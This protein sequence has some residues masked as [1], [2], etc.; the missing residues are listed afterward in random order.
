MQLRLTVIDPTGSHPAVDCIV[1]VAADTMLGAV[2][3]SLLATVGRSD[4]RLFC[5]GQPLTDQTPLGLPPLVDGAVVSAGRPLGQ[6]AKTLLEL[7]VT[8]GPDSGTVHP[9]GPGEHRIGR[10]LKADVRIEDP[11]VSRLHA[12]LSVRPGGV[13]V[14]DLDSTNGTVVGGLQASRTGVPMEVGDVLQVGV[15]RLQLQA[16]DL[17]RAACHA[18]GEGHLQLN[19]PPRLPP[20]E[21]SPTVTL[22]AEPT[23]REKPRV[24][25]IAL[26]VPLVAGIALVAFTGNP[27]YLAF[28]LL[29]PLMVLGT[30]LTDRFGGRRSARAEQ[31][32]Y[33]EALADAYKVIATA[34]ETEE[35]ARHRAHPGA[36]TLLLAATAPTPR[37]WERRR[38]DLD[39]L[40]LR[41]GLADLPAAVGVQE[42]GERSAERPV[43]RS[44]PVTVPLA[45][46][47][48]VGFAGTRRGALAAARFALAQLVAWHSPR[49]L[50]VVLL[51]TDGGGG[52]WDW[53]RWLPHLRPVDGEDAELLVALDSDRVRARL[54]ELGRLLDARAEETSRSRQGR[55]EGRSVVVVLDG[56]R[57]L[58]RVPGVAR[59]LAEGPELG[60]HVLC[61]DEHAVALPVECGATIEVVGETDTALRVTVR[62]SE[63]LDDVVMDGVS[64][65]WANR[66]ARALAPL[67]DATPDEAVA[68]LPTEVGLLDL[69]PF[70]ATDAGALETAWLVSPRSTTVS[71][72]VGV[73][74]EPFT[75][76]LRR[77]GPHALVA[78]TT[79]A[80]KSELLQALVAGLA[81]GNRPDELAFVLIDYKGGAAFKD[82]ARLPHT[83]GTVTDLDGHLTERALS[84][85]GAELRRRETVLRDAGCKDID[86][87]LASRSAGD[88]SM[89]RLVLVLDEFATLAEELPDF[90]GGLVGIAQRGRSLGVHL[91]LATQRPSGVV[92]ADIRANT[93][94]RIALRVTDAGESADVI[95]VKDAATISRATPGRAVARIGAGGVTAFQSARVGRSAMIALPG[96]RVRPAAWA[97]AGTNRL[98]HESGPASGPTD[99]CR[100]VDAACAAAAGLGVTQVQSPWL[101]P[102]G[103]VLPLAAVPSTSP[104]AV[105]YGLLDMPAE[106][107]RAPLVLDLEHGGHL[108]VAGGSR[109]GRS[110]LLRTL[111]G[112]LA[113][114]LAPEEAHLYVIDGGSG[115]LTGL[116]AL[117]HCGAVVS[118]D[119]VARGDRLLVRLTQEIE[120]RQS[121]L[122]AGGFASVA[123]QRAAAE[124]GDRL[125]WLVL[126]VDGW[127]GV[128]AAYDD[129][130]HG[131]PLDTLQRL[132]R[133]GGAAGLRVVLT[134]D[135]GVLT[136]RVGA[137]IIDRLLLRLADPGDYGLAGVPA[138]Q[139]PGVM[140]PGRGLL[141]DGAIEAQVAL[142][143][144][145]PAGPAQQAALAAIATGGEDGQP[146][147]TPVHQRPLRVEPMPIRVNVDTVRVA[148]KAAST[149]PLWTLVG[150]GGDDLD[151]LGVDLDTEGPAFVIGGPAGS[152]R[153]SALLTIARW[154]GHEGVPTV[155][156]APSR[157][158]LTV[159]SGEPGV[160]GVLRA[161]EPDALAGLISEHPSPLVVIADDAEMLHDSPMERPLC[162]LLRR[163]VAP[164]AALVLAASAT[165]MA[166]F[167]RGITVEARR[168]RSGLLLGA[169]GPVEGDL[170]GVRV[171]RGGETRP[172]RGLL[173]IRGRAQ[174]V[175]V[176]LE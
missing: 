33:D 20:P 7:H 101:P 174:P 163:H 31:R 49:H 146:E 21:V 89:P 26:V 74:G 87:Y 6:P 61:I 129:V 168:N 160:L 141:A 55:W 170:F 77:D 98:R 47:G 126:M 110:T 4:G 28:V 109:S 41:V 113:L 27:S 175:Q 3:P 59:L 149:G 88:P 167:F 53:L 15:S 156:V 92:S 140:P 2:R 165:E 95:D 10:A 171:A 94:L 52:A 169:A 11:D 68:E 148:A 76:D 154:L 96:P 164:H 32:A 65:P 57:Q 84:S 139:V 83:V 35:A 136:S 1:D 102:L 63:A 23:P 125:P 144:P 43:A 124:P 16:A 86:D 72:G 121:V 58:R 117:P 99:L 133:D 17:A 69:L 25:V 127:E 176:A 120:R 9:L 14:A 70:D 90:V 173:V 50:G 39:F 46:V 78:G 128:H 100:L 64:Q 51:A 13:T 60:V 82:C 152:G 93:T 42:P 157:S 56:A 85:L 71:L 36:S 162:E 138:R 22:P 116:A 40:L 114:R 153:S 30:F 75:V 150:I 155:V 166:G 158:P 29:S 67:E 147:T 151:P 131:R 97:D 119:Q 107:R 24:P 62:D 161:D 108:L 81:V 122:A 8:G 142:L 135:R 38:N 118:R 54:A 37:L 132:V 34:L 73:D 134:G 159:L 130:D 123:E 18:D 80:G 44:V 66:F 115:G 172:G 104:A 137:S 111:A 112:S 103:P 12:V 145:D 91:V 79:G 106:Q 19:R 48:V 105:P 143:D 45:D 5:A